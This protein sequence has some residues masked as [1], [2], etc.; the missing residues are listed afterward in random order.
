MKINKTA[1]YI[2]LALV[3]VAALY[4]IIPGRPYGFA[5]QIAMALFG[6]AVIKDKKLAFALPLLS[7][8]LSD[9]LFELLYFAGISP[10][11]GFYEGQLTNYVLFALLTVSGFFIKKMSVINIAVASFAAPTAY[12]LISNFM[13]WLSGT[14]GLQRPKTFDGLMMCFADGL[15][16]YKNSIAGTLFFSA[17]F[18]GSYYLIKQYI[19]IPKMD[20]YKF[21][22]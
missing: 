13:V 14:G 15:P 4:R 21:P 12:F 2:L 3:V 1:L 8:V 7:M 9:A 17:L 20:L 10:M 16:F 5:P 11:W 22:S 6:G 19:L 18:F